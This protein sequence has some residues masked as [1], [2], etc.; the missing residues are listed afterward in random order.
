MRFVA[1][2][3]GGCTVGWKCASGAMVVGCVECVDVLGIPGSRSGT[4]MGA[5][6]EE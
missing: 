5:M 3:C 2:W 6:L 1:R 4:S